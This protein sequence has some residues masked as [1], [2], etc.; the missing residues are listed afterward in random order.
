MHHDYISI[1]FSEDL[2]GLGKVSTQK[3]F[4]KSEHDPVVVAHIYKPSIQESEAGGLLQVWSQ[5]G[6]LSGLQPPA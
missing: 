3:M 1:L 5:S 4:Q 2:P 6:L